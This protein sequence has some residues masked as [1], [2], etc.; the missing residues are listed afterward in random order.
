MDRSFELWGRWSQIIILTTS[1]EVWKIYVHLIWFWFFLYFWFNLDS[2]LK[3]NKS[4]LK[5][6]KETFPV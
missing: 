5:L 1:F 3:I 4:P 6:C 2:N